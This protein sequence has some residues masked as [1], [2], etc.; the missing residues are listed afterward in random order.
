MVETVE[1][2]YLILVS[3]SPTAPKRY[4]ALAPTRADRVSTMGP[5]GKLILRIKLIYESKQGK[6]AQCERFRSRAHSGRTR[7]IAVKLT[8]VDLCHGMSLLFDEL[9]YQKPGIP[10]CDG[11]TKNNKAYRKAGLRIPNFA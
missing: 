3:R 6:R 10:P 1:K 4:T 11:S 8:P 2:C 5:L 9:I 7:R